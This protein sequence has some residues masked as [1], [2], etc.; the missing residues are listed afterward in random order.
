ETAVLHMHGHSHLESRTM[1]YDGSRATLRG[2]FSALEQRIEIHDHVTGRREDV[3][4]PLS[5]SGHGG[6]DFGIMR[7]FV[8]AVNGDETALTNARES[9][10]SHLMAFAAEES[11]L[12][13]TVVD[14][15]DFRQRA[16]RSTALL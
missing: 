13:H 5:G 10:E 8:H 14:M 1:R 12:Q 7:S 2:L 4:I 3:P 16:E 6:G 11:R 15:S 9:L